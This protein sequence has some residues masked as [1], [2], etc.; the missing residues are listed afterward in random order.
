MKK[1]I[2]LSLI[3]AMLFGF[4]PPIT[5]TAVIMP[6]W[7][8]LPNGEGA[9]SSEIG[10]TILAEN[11][12]LTEA[13][14]I[15]QIEIWSN[16]AGPYELTFN[17]F[18]NT[19]DEGEY[20]IP[21][22]LVCGEVINSS[23][24]EDDICPQNGD[25]YYYCNYRHTL[26][27]DPPLE[28][29]DGH[30]WLSVYGSAESDFG[31]ST[32]DIPDQLNTYAFKYEDYPWDGQYLLHAFAFRLLEP[33][34]TCPTS[35]VVANTN[36][37][38]AG[39]LRQALVDVCAGGTITFDASL[40]G[41]TIYLT[42]GQLTLDEDVTID[43]SALT[44][45]VTINGETSG[46]RVLEVNSGVTATLDSLKISHGN[47]T[48]SGG[49]IYNQGNLTV[50]NAV[51]L[52][53]MSTQSGAGIYNAGGTLLVTNSTLTIN[54]A[55]SQ[56]GAIFNESGGSATVVNS[57][58]TGNEGTSG[59]GIATGLDTITSI[60]SSTLTEN[61]ATSTSGSGG[62]LRN[63]GTMT[64]VNSTLVENTALQWGGGICNDG[65]LTLYNST[66][67]GN[68]GNTGG[69]EGH[70]LANLSG[71]ILHYAN[72]IIANPPNKGACI[73]DGTISTN[74][75]NLVEE[76]GGDYGCGA[77]LNIDPLL[78]P[79]QDN[80]G[81]T[82]TM[83]LQ[84][85]SPAIHAGEDTICADALVGNV[86]QRDVTRPQGAHCDIGAYELEV[87]PWAVSYTHLRAHET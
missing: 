20:N 9:Y 32:T 15:A 14:S 2:N 87:T 31:W 73:N 49:G 24:E 10:Q 23:G 54:Y 69:Y 45:R 56:G 58:F 8:Q 48:G 60:T 43:A 25:G 42:S 19:T 70:G 35:V 75:N 18:A 6:L 72:T 12:N 61:K 11:F 64:V 84:T 21:G 17:I 27:F 38:G 76:E 59:G 47:V 79:L 57:T 5:A 85:G 13:S 33:L 53:N 50:N 77:I 83:A 29:A 86:D 74:I 51:L 28:L 55:A 30:Y 7:E 36:D 67:S 68:A 66:L 39:S 40:S 4:L 3:L 26:S 41:E 78:G 63:R 81:P 62:G 65:T 16:G 46:G 1:F 52:N 34:Q 82:Q 71:G 44:N 37:S 22:E 80:G